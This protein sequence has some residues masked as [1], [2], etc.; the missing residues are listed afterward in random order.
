M[1]RVFMLIAIVG[2]L[3]FL[4]NAWGGA[5]FITTLEFDSINAGASSSQDLKLPS[6]VARCVKITGGMLGDPATTFNIAI[7]D[8][9][10]EGIADERYGVDAIVG[11]INDDTPVYLNSEH[12]SK[13]ASLKLTNSGSAARSMEILF[14][15]E[16]MGSSPL[17]SD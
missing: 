10:A 8:N 16:S 15:T 4:T 7:Y 2:V 14:I 13:V 9:I 17:T 5:R 12:T 1:K 6:S 3:C 11:L